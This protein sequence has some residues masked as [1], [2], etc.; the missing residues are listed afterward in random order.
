MGRDPCRSILGR[1]VVQLEN[2]TSSGWEARNEWVLVAFVT[3]WASCILGDSRASHTGRRRDRT[4]VS[5]D[6]MHAEVRD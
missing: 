2:Q 3:V 1:Q 6:K 5:K 4:L